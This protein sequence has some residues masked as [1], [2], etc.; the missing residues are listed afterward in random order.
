MVEWEEPTKRIHCA[1]N[2]GNQTYEQITVFLL[3][4]ANAVAQP[5]EK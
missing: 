5:N 4:H 3:D 1:V 2:V